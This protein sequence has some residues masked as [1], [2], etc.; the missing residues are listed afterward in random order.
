MHPFYTQT[1]ATGHFDAEA[2]MPHP[3]LTAITDQFLYTYG[4]S[5]LYRRGLFPAFSFAATSWGE[6]QDIL[7][8]VRDAGKTIALHRDVAGICLHNQHGENC[9]RSFAQV[10]SGE[11]RLG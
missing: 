8:R 9:S 10:R 3:A 2:G 6:D 7:S 11:I 1:G 4:F 5:F